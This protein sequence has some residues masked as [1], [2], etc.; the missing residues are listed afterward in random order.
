MGNFNSRKNV[1]LTFWSGSR[2]LVCSELKWPLMS[3]VGL[4]CSQNKL[5]LM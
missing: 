5:P 4:S 3:A 1:A 2:G